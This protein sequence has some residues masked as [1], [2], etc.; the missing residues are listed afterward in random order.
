[1]ARVH[2]TYRTP[3]IAILVYVTIIIGLALSGG[4]RAL[5]VLASMSLLLVYLA[6]CLGTLR[7]RY[8]RPPIPGTFRIP[9]GPAVPVVASAVVVWLLAQS[10]LREV[11]TM[12][13]FI[14]AA[15]L[16]Y[17]IRRTWPVRE[18]AFQQ[19]PP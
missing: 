19:P 16:Y 12:A 4:F 5:A 11:V 6:I 17:L 18:P 14:G 3:W 10:T 8:S 1:M 13:V 15:T 2:P 7:I 9:G